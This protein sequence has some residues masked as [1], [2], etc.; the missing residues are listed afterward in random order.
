MT[1]VVNES[2]PTW[3]RGLKS[4]SHA[5]TEGL[6][7]VAPYMGAW[8]EIPVGI[9]ISSTTSESLPTWERG[10]KS[11]LL[12]HSANASESLPTWERGLK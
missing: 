9:V 3:E 12:P 8:I 10:L 11:V 7:H 5:G 1:N 2:L 6:Q 4:G